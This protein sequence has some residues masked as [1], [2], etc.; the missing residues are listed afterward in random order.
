MNSDSSFEKKKSFSALEKAPRFYMFVW[1]VVRRI[2]YFPF[3]IARQSNR[4]FSIGL[5]V[6][7]SR[8]RRASSFFFFCKNILHDQFVFCYGIC[9]KIALQHDSER[10]NRDYKSINAFVMYLHKKMDDLKIVNFDKSS[11]R[12]EKSENHKKRVKIYFI[13]TFLCTKTTR[14]NTSSMTSD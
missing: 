3:Y 9:C 7:L 1:L 13:S 6:R 8:I 10:I 2:F 12:D 11:R 5:C 4:R 14:K